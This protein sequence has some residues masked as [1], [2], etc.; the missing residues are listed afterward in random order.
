VNFLSFGFQDGT[1]SGTLGGGYPGGTP[2]PVSFTDHL[3]SSIFISGV[4]AYYQSADCIVLG[5]KYN[6]D[7]SAEVKAA[8][9][10]QYVSGPKARTTADLAAATV[11]HPVSEA[12]LSL[13]AAS[14]GWDRER[15][16]YQAFLQA[17]RTK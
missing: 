12:D 4:S 7:R 9:K 8:C 3:L 15:A 17:N 13:A 16:D 5:F 14:E 1:S 11:A 2:T 10:A 6:P